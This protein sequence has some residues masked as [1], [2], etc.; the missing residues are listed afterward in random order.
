MPKAKAK[1]KKGVTTKLVEPPRPS[2]PLPAPESH[3]LTEQEEPSSEVDL[4]SGASVSGNELPPEADEPAAKK[5]KRTMNVAKNPRKGVVN[6]TDDQEKE[7]GEWLLTNP[8]FYDKGCKTFRD[9]RKK[10]SAIHDKCTEMGID[11]GAYK[12]WYHTMR[13]GFGRLTMKVGS[14]ES[15]T[16]EKWILATF[17]FLK[18]HIVRHESR[19]LGVAVILYVK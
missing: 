6:F 5:K 16:R 3:V 17:S 11:P 4:P 13:S 7:L 15:T 18:S 14:R 1:A 12:S 19:Q 9:S 8:M 10:Q 2:S